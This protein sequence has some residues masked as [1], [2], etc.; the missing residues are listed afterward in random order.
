MVS[1]PSHMWAI[2]SARPAEERCT[3][4][5]IPLGAPSK[6]YFDLEFDRT[7]QPDKNGPAVVSNLI[8]ATCQVLKDLYD[9]I[10]TE[11]DV[12]VLDASTP[13][14]F[15]QHLIFQGFVFEVR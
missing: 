1:H 13:A 8:L 15:S 9:L 3:Y 2:H 12:L 14:K 7:V 10:V 4:E 6:L 5:V 11:K